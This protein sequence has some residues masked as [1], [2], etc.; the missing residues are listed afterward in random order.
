M[1][2]FNRLFASMLN[3]VNSLSDDDV[4]VPSPKV[5]AKAKAKKQPNKKDPEDRLLN[6]INVKRCFSIDIEP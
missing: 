3:P 4:K 5:K 2:P 1:L 6:W